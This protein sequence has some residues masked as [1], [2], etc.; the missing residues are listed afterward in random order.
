M[1]WRKLAEIVGQYLKKGSRIYVEGKLQMRSWDDESGQKRYTTEVVARSASDGGGGYGSDPGPA[2]PP[3]YGSWG[4]DAWMRCVWCSESDWEAGPG[5]EPGTLDH[6]SNVIPFHYP[7]SRH[8][9]FAGCFLRK[10][11]AR[12]PAHMISRCIWRGA[13]GSVAGFA[14]TLGYVNNRRGAYCD[15]SL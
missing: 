7:A 14:S 11:V 9:I 8:N 10:G 12:A 5:F 2:A 13:T 15:E 1:F 3:E 6:E 4:R